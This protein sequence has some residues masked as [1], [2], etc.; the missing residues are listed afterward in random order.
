MQDQAKKQAEA[1]RQIEVIE[2][3]E[4][5][6][7]VVKVVDKQKKVMKRIAKK[8]YRKMRNYLKKMDGSRVCA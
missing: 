5:E 3:A 4:H 8:H 2:K 6:A 7:A 1:S